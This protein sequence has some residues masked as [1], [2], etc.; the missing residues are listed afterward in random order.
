MGFNKKIVNYDVL[1]NYL[2]EGRLKEYYGNNDML[3]FEDTSS[4][5]I[6]NL[7]LEGKSDTEILSIINQKNK[8]HEVY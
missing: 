5:R 6:H 1:L 2:K 8:N 3:I 7:Y 4:A